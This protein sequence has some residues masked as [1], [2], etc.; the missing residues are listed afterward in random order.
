M[1]AAAVALSARLHQDGVLSD[2]AGPTSGVASLTGRKALD[3][4]SGRAVSRTS[5]ARGYEPRPQDATP[6]SA[7]QDRLRK[8]P[9]HE[10]GWQNVLYIRYVVKKYLRYVAEIP[11][12]CEPTARGMPISLAASASAGPAPAHETNVAVVYGPR[13]S[14]GSHQDFSSSNHEGRYSSRRATGPRASWH[15]H[16][17]QEVTTRE[18]HSVP[19]RSLV[20]ALTACCELFKAAIYL[21][22]QRQ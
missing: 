4:Q 19:R 15:V 22:G 21:R 11:A 6:R 12:P 5:R 9:L 16:G 18:H 14:G 20:N 17:R 7:F 3:F 8:T 13:F 2:G 1:G 10:R